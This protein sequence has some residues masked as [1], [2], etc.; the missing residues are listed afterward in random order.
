MKFRQD[1]G[2]MEELLEQPGDLTVLATVR[3][4]RKLN[5]VFVEVESEEGVSRRTLKKMLRRVSL[6]LPNQP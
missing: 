6:E 3:L 1:I 4:M 5:R 2:K